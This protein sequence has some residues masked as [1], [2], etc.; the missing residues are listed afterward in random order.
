MEIPKQQHLNKRLQEIPDS[1]YRE[2]M[3]RN[4]IAW[5]IAVA[6]RL[7]NDRVMA[8]DVVQEAFI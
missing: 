4:N 2:E 6:D 5:M 8:E 3:V 1:T 7:L